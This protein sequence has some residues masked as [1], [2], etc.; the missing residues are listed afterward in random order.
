MRRALPLLAFSVLIAGCDRPAPGTCSGDYCGTIV[1]AAI[2]EPVTLLPAVSD[3]A[4]DRDVFGQIFLRL[5][6]IGVG[7]NTV[8][9]GGFEP[10]LADRWDWSDSVTLVFHLNDKARWQDGRPVTAED[11]AFTF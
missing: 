5:A 10:Q 2:G 6:D 4:I 1:F 11:V 8:G 7:G 9:D 3:E